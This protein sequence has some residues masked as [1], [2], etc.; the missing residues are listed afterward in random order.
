[1]RESMISMMAQVLGSGQ[2]KD[3]FFLL[4]RQA[5]QDTLA[6][7]YVA[8]NIS[9]NNQLEFY[10]PRLVEILSDLLDVERCSI[11]LYDGF[12]DTLFC[13]VIT[14]RL[15][16]P[17]SFPRES[18][19]A[20]CSVFN[21]GQARHFRKINDEARDELGEYLKIN[22]KLHQVI[23][24]VLFVPIKLGNHAIGCFELANKKGSQDFTTNDFTMVSQVC[25]EIASGLISHEMKH[26][27]KKE[28]DDELKYFKG[29]M[30]Q[31]YNTLLIPMVSEVTTVIAHVLQAEK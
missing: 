12:K 31:S 10:L 17:I 19:N 14:G 8:K 13:K 1:M 2:T 5:I 29:L 28:F 30:N 26:N 4:T 25:D 6:L 23:K 22:E 20:I 24:N 3:N 15:R 9:F 21:T 27:I 11:Y 16:E 18:K 7:F